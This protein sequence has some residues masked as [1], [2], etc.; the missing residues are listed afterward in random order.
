MPHRPFPSPKDRHISRQSRR[1]QVLLSPIIFLRISPNRLRKEDE[2]KTSFTT[3][4][5]TYCFVCMLK[6]LKNVG[7]LFARMTNAILGCQ[8]VW[9]ILAYIDHIVVT[10]KEREDHVSDLQETFTNLREAS[11]KLNLVSVIW[12][13]V[14]SSPTKSPLQPRWAEDGKY[15]AQPR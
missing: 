10:S 6:G 13:Q 5:G 8:I 12:T 11:L 15:E 2:E 9:N 4:F 14:T 7:S 1:M 3:P